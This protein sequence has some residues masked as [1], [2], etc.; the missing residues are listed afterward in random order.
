MAAI[1]WRRTSSLLLCYFYAVLLFLGLRL[2]QSMFGIGFPQSRKFIKK[3]TTDPSIQV[4][5]SVNQ[6]NK[7]FHKTGGN[8]ADG[9]P[10]HTPDSDTMSCCQ[11]CPTR[12]YRQ[13]SFLELPAPV[14]AATE[15]NFW[16]WYDNLH[17]DEPKSSSSSAPSTSSPV[18]GF[19]EEKETIQDEEAIQ[20]EP[21][22]LFSRAQVQRWLEERQSAV[23]ARQLEIMDT[24]ELLLF[25]EESNDLR[26][27]S[28]STKKGPEVYRNEYNSLN[29]NTKFTYPKSS[30]TVRV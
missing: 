15:A 5:D 8:K 14:K 23:H 29:H 25:M 9:T 16:R 6:F 13:L 22:N 28:K 2:C 24:S 12:F 21:A 19:V 7:E 3:Y 10:Y 1:G 4:A 18:D 30:K 20:E 11:V 26:K 27:A 17:K